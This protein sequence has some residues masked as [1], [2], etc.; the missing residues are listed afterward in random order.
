MYTGCYG[1]QSGVYLNSVTDLTPPP[2]FIG[3]RESALEEGAVI[4]EGG[5]W[6]GVGRT[7][8]LWYTHSSQRGGAGLCQP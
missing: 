3:A 7:T 6:E 5:V 2:V 1:L 8:R 4:G